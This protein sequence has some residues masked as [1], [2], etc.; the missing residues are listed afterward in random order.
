MKQK[1]EKDYNIYSIPLFQELILKDE[2]LLYDLRVEQKE[3]NS[4]LDDLEIEFNRFIKDY[5]LEKAN[6]VLVEAKGIINGLIEERASKRWDYLEY[7]LVDAK[8]SLVNQIHKSSKEAIKFLQKR[9]VK[10]ALDYY[11]KI[12]E[13]LEKNI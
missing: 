5:Y 3:F 1:Y 2:N 11:E 9:E 7:T 4:R 8:R 13:K 6:S 12:I 10:K